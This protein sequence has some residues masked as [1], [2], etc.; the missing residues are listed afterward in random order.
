MKMGYLT[1][2][3]L[4][5][6][7]FASIVSEMSSNCV[8]NITKHQTLI[9]FIYPYQIYQQQAKGAEGRYTFK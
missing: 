8:S 6:F 4:I 3:K 7:Q 1:L 9:N 5:V 2:I